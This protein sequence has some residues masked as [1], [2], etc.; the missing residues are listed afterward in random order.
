[1]I[2]DPAVFGWAWPVFGAAAAASTFAGALAPRIGGNRRLWV[3]S[4]L[5][6]ACAVAVPLVVPG[7]AGIVLAA[8]GV[9]G[10]FVVATMA[11]MQEARLVRGAHATGLM[12]ALTSAFALGQVAGPLLVSSLVAAGGGFRG[13][14][15][16]A[17]ALL[18]ASAWALRTRQSPA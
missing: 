13:A 18:V 10:T 9:G 11:G 17:A 3:I 5:V 6:M 12:A 4:H 8:V 1:V 14:L 15:L 2:G 7:M 16:L